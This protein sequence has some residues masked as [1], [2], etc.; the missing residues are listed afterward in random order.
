DGDGA[1]PHG[2]LAVREDQAGLAG[3]AEIEG[4]A[5][6][7]LGAGG[8]LEPRQADGRSEGQHGRDE[9]VHL[10]VAPD[11]DVEAGAGADLEADEVATEGLG[12]RGADEEAGVIAHGHDVVAEALL[13]LE[14][15]AATV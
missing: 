13:E 8:G 3:H 14:Q 5:G 12:E 7:T 1:A 4:A 2:P 6:V 9:D 15:G 10:A 11:A